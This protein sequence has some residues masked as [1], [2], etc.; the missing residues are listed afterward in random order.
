MKVRYNYCVY[1][2]SHQQ[3]KAAKQFGCNRVVWNDALRMVRDRDC[4]L[5]FGA[6]SKLVTTQAKKTP[7]RQWLSEVSSVGLQQSI[8][9]LKSAINKYWD[10]RLGRSN[11]RNV[12]FPRF[13]KKSNQQSSRYN[14]NAFKIRNGKL[15]LAKIGWIKVV[16]SRELPSEPSSVTLIKNTDGTYEVSFVVETQPISVKPIRPSIGVDFGIKKFASLSVGDPVL[17]PDYSKLDRKIRRFQRHL[18]RQVKGSNRWYQTRLK[19][20]K[21]KRKLANIRKDFLHK[22]TTKLVRENQTVCLEDLNVS[23][24]LKNR[25]LARKISEQGWSMA[26]QMC[27]AKAT[28]IED[29]TVSIISRWEPTSQTCSDCGYRWGKIDLS[30]RVI[31]CISCGSIHD[32][33][34]NAAKNIDRVGVGHSHDSKRTVSECKP[35]LEAVRVDLPT[36]TYS[37]SEPLEV[38]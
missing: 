6:I 37:D 7:E 9:D 35:S 23:G 24:M 21:L 17:S 19:I 15:F 31:K 12:G 29:R 38:A 16:W 28:Q 18:S 13:K 2:E 22:F 32:R 8:N 27:E 14:K 36:Q 34:D 5:K 33:D 4:D 1:L 25:K 30:V 11:D 10:C 3:T 20:S 26:R